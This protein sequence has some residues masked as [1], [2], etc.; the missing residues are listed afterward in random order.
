MMKHAAIGVLLV[1][2]V[3]TGCALPGGGGSGEVTIVPATTVPATT[4]RVDPTATSAPP[5]PS[6]PPA[7]TTP[8]PPPPPATPPPTPTV[9]TPAN[10]PADLTTLKLDLQLVA[11]GFDTPVYVTHAGDGSGRLFVVEKRGTIAIVQDGERLPELFFDIVPLVESRASERGLLSI[12]FHPDYPNNGEFFVYYNDKAGD[13]IIARYRVSSDPN[14][15]D[16]GSEEVILTIAQPAANHNGGLVL[17][18]PDGYLYIGMGD[19]GQAGDPWGNA[20]NRDVLL[21]KMLRID[22]DGA[23]PYAIPPDNP[24]VNTDGVRPEIWAWGLRNPWRF[25]FDRATGDMYIGDVGQNAYEEIHYQP[26]A[27]RGGENYGWDIMEGAA[28]YPED[29]PCSQEG[30]ELPVVV[31]S[32]AGGHCSVTGGYVY[33]GGAFPQFDGLYFFGDYCSGNIWALRQ[34]DDGWESVRVRE[35]NLTISSFGE[36]EAGEHYLCDMW[37]GQLYRLVHPE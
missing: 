20:Q 32:H 1:L 25:S 23:A 26:A 10:A 36:D 27:S 21:G 6:P 12:A 31:Y 34:T 22:V 9:A 5:P 24:F 19:G 18:G 35:T 28:C 11:E 2:L 33:R 14:R 17:F 3:T 4:G 15:A 30:L 37:D 7:A 13:S 8:A 16:M 29:Q